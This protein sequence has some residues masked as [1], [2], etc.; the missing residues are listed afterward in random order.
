MRRLSELQEAHQLMQ[1][2]CRDSDQLIMHLT[3]NLPDAESNQQLTSCREWVQEH[4]SK[5]EAMV[6]M[7]KRNVTHLL[8]LL[9]KIGQRYS[10]VE[11][12]GIA[13]V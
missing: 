2:I 10:E 11:G 13:E 8:Q 9:V 7:R 4:H 12:R 3:L 1:Q 5:A 6:C